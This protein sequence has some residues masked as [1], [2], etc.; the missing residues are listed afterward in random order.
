[1]P[2]KFN[3]RLQNYLIRGSGQLG[4]VLMFTAASVMSSSATL[5]VYWFA[6]P[7]Q[8]AVEPPPPTGEE[9]D[10]VVAEVQAEGPITSIGVIFML[11]GLNA[12]IATLLGIIISH[13]AYGPA[14]RLRHFVEVLRDGHFDRRVQL[15]DS[16]SHQDLARALNELAESLEQR[17]QRAG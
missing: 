9:G 1:M 6:S 12:T 4:L 3:R 10:E 2:K 17:A 14:V 8:A 16:D 11:L 7:P 15:R 5:L 13:R